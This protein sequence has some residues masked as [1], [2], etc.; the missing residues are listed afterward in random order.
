[1]KLPSRDTVRA[2]SCTHWVVHVG[3]FVFVLAVLQVFDHWLDPGTMTFLP[4]K[5]SPHFTTVE[6]DG[7]VPMQSVTVPTPETC[8]VTYWM[9]V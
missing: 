6:Y 8:S 9:Q 1:M 5:Q 3:T 4:W 2:L 7:S